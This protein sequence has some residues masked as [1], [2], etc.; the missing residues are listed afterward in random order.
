MEA[1]AGREHSRAPRD[2]RL[3]IITGSGPAGRALANR[4]TEDR[5]LSVLAPSRPAA[6]TSHPY[7]AM[8]AGFAK[9]TRAS[10]AGAGRRCRKSISA[11]GCSRQ[12]QA[13]SS[14]A[15]LPSTT[16]P[17][18]RFNA[19]DYDA[20]ADEVGAAPAGAT[21]RFLPHSKRA[22]DNQRFANYYHGYGGPVGVSGPVAPRCRSARCSCV[23]AQEFGLAFQPGFQRREPGRGRDITS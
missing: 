2:R 10:P 22:E 18:T 14:A 3:H 11:A 8:R 19:K 12:T 17:D 9:M 16:P 23:P 20:W 15:A 7:F 1:T 4:L 6:A 13:R 5:A 21:A